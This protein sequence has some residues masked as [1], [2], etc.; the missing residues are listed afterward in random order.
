MSERKLSDEQRRNIADRYIA[1]ESRRDLA[2]EYSVSQ[3]TVRKVLT[4]LNARRPP[5]PPATSRDL[6]EFKSRARSILWRQE[7]SAEKTT[8]KA[9]ENRVASLASPEG[10]G[11]T[12]NQAVIRASKEFPCLARLFREY[13][14]SAY[15]PN[16]ESHPTIQHFGR[17]VTMSDIVCEGKDQSYRDSLRWAI[18]AAGAFLR[19]GRN[20][21]ICPCDAA[22]YV[23][24]Q[25]LDEPKD[26]LAKVGQIESKGDQGDESQRSARK[27]GNRSISEID[28]MLAELTPSEPDA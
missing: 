4:T 5:P 19:T 11:M 23:Y 26:F 24:K 2:T 21:A 15:D 27:A 16:P 25:A 22:W 12:E 13:D 10:G 3:T 7:H 17:P 9:W 1:G 20:P 18:D 6:V 14:V 28:L 8:Y